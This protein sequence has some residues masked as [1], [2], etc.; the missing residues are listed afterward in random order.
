MAQILNVIKVNIK[1]LKMSY[2][3]LQ[4]YMHE[5]PNLQQNQL[6]YNQ[7]SKETCI[8]CYNNQIL[9]I[10]IGK[11]CFSTFLEKE[12]IMLCFLKCK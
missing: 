12:M 11:W 8:I 10:S 4:T 7:N 9:N 3:A 1:V 5:D 2:L 6:F